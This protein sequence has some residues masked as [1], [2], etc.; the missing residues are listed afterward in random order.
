[1]HNFG[2][3]NLVGLHGLF[4]K[5]TFYK[6]NATKP[7]RTFVCDSGPGCEP[8]TNKDG[9]HDGRGRKISGHWL[10]DNVKDTIS[11]YDLEAVL[12][13]GKEIEP[14]ENGAY[15]DN[16]A[17]LIVPKSDAPAESENHP[18]GRAAWKAPVETPAAVVA[19]VVDGVVAA[20]AHA[21]T[22]AH[23]ADV[24]PTAVT[25]PWDAAK[26]VALYQGGMKVS[27]IAE[28]FGDR[29]RQNRVRKA[30]RDAGVYKEGK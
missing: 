18:R 28:H 6:P 25:A 8:S 16:T 30:C 23:L 24:A 19:S 14:E 7:S 12:V 10:S 4:K 20:Q 22:Q 5:K 11:S 3:V 21:N 17:V 1:M 29:N 26:A 2:Q 13:D 27:D 15:V 9:S